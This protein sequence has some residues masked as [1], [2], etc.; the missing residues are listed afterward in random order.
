MKIVLNE[1]VLKHL[2]EQET[3][4]FLTYKTLPDCVKNNLTQ[5]ITSSA[6]YVKKN[7]EVRH[8]A[9]RRKL[10]AYQKSNA[11]KTEK[12]K[13]VLK[14]NNLLQVYDVNVYLKTLAEN[15]AKDMPD[16]E[17]KRKAASASYRSLIISNILG[18]HCSGEFY[19]MREINNIKERFG[20]E[21]YKGLTK[22]MIKSMDTEINESNKNI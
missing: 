3:I 9:F 17:A 4:E 1:S 14:N 18:F 6:A 5:N 8:M 15:R 7:G 22:T 12:Q 16:D 10:L 2:F 11:E 13:N 21:V 19:D 20:E